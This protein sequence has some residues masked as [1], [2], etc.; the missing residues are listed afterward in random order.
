MSVDGINISRASPGDLPEPL[1][2]LTAVNLPHE[3]VAQHLDGFLIAR[4]ADGKT[5]GSVGIERHGR[6]GFLRS[7]AVVPALQRSGLGSR[8][9]AAVLKRTTEEGIE[10]VLLLTSTA[11]DFFS[12]RFGFTEANRSDYDARLAGSPEWELPRC[13]SAVLMTL[14]IDRGV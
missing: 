3:G 9:T 14:K 13:S 1:S 7:A 12:K 4:D 8:L 11:R 10:E 6:L 2:L 5:V